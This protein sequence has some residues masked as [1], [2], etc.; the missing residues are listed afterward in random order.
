[1][2][3]ENALLKQKLDNALQELE[4]ANA[5]NENISKQ[6]LENKKLYTDADNKLKRI[7]KILNEDTPNKD[8][9]EC[10]IENR[11]K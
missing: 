1:M 10:V 4:K 6:L 3:R 5:E 9:E 11:A 2:T 7:N 8:T